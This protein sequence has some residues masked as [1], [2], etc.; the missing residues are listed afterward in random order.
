MMQMQSTPITNGPRP[1]LVLTAGAGA[2]RPLAVVDVRHLPVNLA[3]ALDPGLRL[4]AGRRTIMQGT[5]T[6]AHA[7]HEGTRG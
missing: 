3:A 5:S 1:V 4:A 6:S 7:P 2:W